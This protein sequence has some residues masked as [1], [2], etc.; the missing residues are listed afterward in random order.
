M[1]RSG[2][3][4]IDPVRLD[5]IKQ[6]YIAGEPYHRMI[7]EINISYSLI[8]RAIKEMGL[9]A[10]AN[11]NVIPDEKRI[12]VIR[13]YRDGM[14][15]KT[16]AKTV[17]IR[18]DNAAKILKEAGENPMLRRDIN[19][20]K[21]T[22]ENGGDEILTVFQTEKDISKLIE[23]FEPKYGFK[24]RSIEAWIERNGL[25]IE[26]RKLHHRGDFDDIKQGVCADYLSGMSVRKLRQKYS[27]A[28]ETIHLILVQENVPTRSKDQI[29]RMRYDSELDEMYGNKRGISGQQ[30]SKW[31]KSA[32]Q[33]GITFEVSLEYC[34]ALFEEQDGKCYYTALSMIST[35]D[36]RTRMKEK[37][38]PYLISL[39]R[40]SSALGY[41]E[42]NVV[43]CCKNINYMKH[44]LEENVF[45][46]FL[47]Q[48]LKSLSPSPQPTLEAIA[49]TEDFLVS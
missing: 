41:T 18:L 9:A 23:I 29:V 25:V 44:T 20:R 22:H 35:L 38:S 48:I 12:E 33:R 2:P 32:E 26:R 31:K 5:K 39:D 40:K 49:N 11:P 21:I 28:H 7:S 34:Q 17:H 46:S 45:K 6:M 15:V 24:R 4:P 19:S 36:K 47:S 13:L 42:S 30:F 37:G 27:I 1:P 43:L 16:I 10:R 8:Q 14:E 3:R